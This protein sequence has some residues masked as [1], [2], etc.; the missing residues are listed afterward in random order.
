MGPGEV[1]LKRVELCS[2][3][4]KKPYV[5]FAI[6]F[7]RGINVSVTQNGVHSEWGTLTQKIL[8]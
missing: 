7:F 4:L 3:L 2:K 1:R 6:A 8:S 5:C